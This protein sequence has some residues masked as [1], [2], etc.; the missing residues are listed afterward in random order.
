MSEFTIQ[1]DDNVPIPSRARVSKYN[2]PFAD[3]KVGQSFFISIQEDEDEKDL[4]RLR[5]RLRNAVN[6]YRKAHDLS[7]SKFA[8]HQVLE[9]QGGKEI[10]GVRVWRTK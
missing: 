8:V 2:Y 10:A 5:H 3:M 1:L 4:T 9:V 6:S 7:D